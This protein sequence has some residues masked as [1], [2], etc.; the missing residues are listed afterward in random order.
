MTF[1]K[2]Y[3]ITVEPAPLPMQALHKSAVLA[4]S[5]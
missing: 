1:H 5:G 2:S 3:H 4:D